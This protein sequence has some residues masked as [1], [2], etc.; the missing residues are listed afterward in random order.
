MKY[1]GKLYG[2]I[3]RNYIQLV[4]TSEELDAMERERDAERDLANRLAAALDSTRWDS[5]IACKA[6]LDR[7]KE[8]RK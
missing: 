4:I 2:K 7:W 1:S 8:A 5:P 3:G 6:A